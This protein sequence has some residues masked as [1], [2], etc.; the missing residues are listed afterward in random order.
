MRTPLSTI[1]ILHRIGK[2]LSKA[3][4]VI[5]VIAFVFCTAALICTACGFE[6]AVGRMESIPLFGGNFGCACHVLLSLAVASLGEILVAR[7]STAY[8]SSELEAG[9]PFDSDNASKLRNL[10]IVTVAVPLATTLI[11]KILYAVL[12]RKFGSFDY[13]FDYAGAPIAVGIMFIILSLICR[14]GAE[15]DTSGKQHTGEQI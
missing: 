13:S 8:F 12:V 6:F 9:T 3:A 7:R 15:I 10:G 11:S 5:S 2:I 1:Q 4:L 14:Y